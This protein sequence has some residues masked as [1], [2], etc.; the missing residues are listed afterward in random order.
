MTADGAQTT[1]A[2]GT[3]EPGTIEP[4][5]IEP[6]MIGPGMIGPGINVHWRGNLYVALFGSFTT[7]VGMTLFLPFLPLY[8]AHLG[9][10]SQSAIVQW[11]G[12]AFGATFLAAGMVA[13]LWGKLADR[14]G[15]KSMLIRASLGM[16]IMISLIGI[17]QNVYQLV[18]LRLLTGLAGGYSSGAI[19]LVAIQTPK[20]RSGWA[21]GTL[22]TGVLAGSIMGPLFGGFLPDIIGIRETFFLAGGMIFVA[23]L[24][25]T[26][27]IRE[28]PALRRRPPAPLTVSPWSI[29]PDR[30]PI[31]I[32]LVTGMLLMLANMSIEPIIT[33]YVAQLVP[34]DQHVARLAGIV[35]A[36]TA[37]ASIAAAPRVGRL[38][39]R[40]GA[41]SV[42]T[43]GLAA[44]AVLLI[45]Q[46]FVTSIWQLIALRLLMGFAL[47]GL[48][49][50]ITSVIRHSV[51]DRVAGNILGYSV[52][53][54][55]A[56]QVI[57]PL[58]GGFIAAHLGM[59]AVFVAT[60]IVMLAGAIFS[61]LALART[62]RSAA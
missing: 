62:A 34:G 14:Y 18:V 25:T 28:D 21:L 47:A 23:F 37:L 50:S 52:S 58:M 38:A 59:R 19:S 33:V 22:S 55:F 46:A 40:I 17:A 49:P 1:T 11:S 16:A 26:F 12:V 53:A 43:Y 9:V 36:A 29:I 24:C 10:T 27:F 8:V 5:T 31:Y 54:Q 32:M 15:R 20:D 2:P 61:R 39:D 30:R 41:R 56:G 7:I 57:G 48:L 6:G 35:M 4:G 3:I 51:P 45:P 44:S 60:S 42:V 13:P